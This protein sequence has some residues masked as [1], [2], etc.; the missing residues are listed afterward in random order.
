MPGAISGGNDSSMKVRGLDGKEYK[1]SLSN[2]TSD[3]R[4]KSSGHMDARL[5][6]GEFYPFDSVFEEVLFPGCGTSLY[7]DFFLPQR[8]LAVEIQGRQHREYVPHFHRGKTGFKNQKNRDNL[9]IE[10]CKINKIILV[11]LH[12][13]ERDVWRAILANPWMAGDSAGE[14]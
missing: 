2:R 3:N 4:N 12:D 5:L 14:A 10:F 6:I 9:K 1:L 8:R 13:D 7:V 11:T